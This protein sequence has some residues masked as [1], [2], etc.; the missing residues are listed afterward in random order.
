MMINSIKGKNI[1]SLYGDF[2]VDFRK[3]PLSDS[4]LFAIT[5]DT[6]SGKST[7]LDTLCLAL[8]GKTPRLGNDRK[9]DATNRYVYDPYTANITMRDPRR[10]MSNGESECYAEVNFTGNDGEEY[11]SSWSC[12]RAKTGTLQPA[13]IKLSLLKSNVPV[14]CERAIEEVLG[15]DFDQ[16]C[17]T[18][19]LSQGEFQKFLEASDNEK[20]DILEKITGTD[21][22]FQI[23]FEV[24]QKYLDARRNLENIQ[25]RTKGLVILSPEDR[26]NKEEDLKQAETEL[27]DKRVDSKSIDGQIKW[28]AERK[29]RF[30][31]LDAAQGESEAAKKADEGSAHIKKLVT[32]LESLRA[33]RPDFTL[34]KN[35]V[36][37]VETSQ[38][39]LKK[40]EESLSK[41]SE[42]QESAESALTNAQAEEASFKEG[43]YKIQQ[44]NILRA[45]DINSKMV[46]FDA[47]YQSR[48]TDVC[49]LSNAIDDLKRQITV[50]NTNIEQLKLSVSELEEWFKANDS[51]S[52]ICANFTEI[53]TMLSS[54]NTETA[55]SRNDEKKAQDEQKEL[56]RLKGILKEQTDRQVRIQ[57]LLPADIAL[58]RSHLVDGEVCPVCGSKVHPDAHKGL[59]DE[60][61]DEKK[62]NK[63]KAEAIEDLWEKIENTK[64]QISAA[65]I[66]KSTFDKTAKEH[67][68]EAMKTSN[69]LEPHF[70]NLTDWKTIPNLLPELTAIQK[71]WTEKN[72]DLQKAKSGKATD[73][74]NRDL[75]KKQAEDKRSE[76]TSKEGELTKVK[77]SLDSFSYELKCLIGEMTVDEAEKQNEAA[78]NARTNKVKE[79][80]KAKSDSDNN[81]SS[82]RGQN[83]KITETRDKS[84]SEKDEYEGKVNSWLDSANS[85]RTPEDLLDKDVLAKLFATYQESWIVSERAKLDKLKHNVETC[86]TIF[87]ERKAKLDEWEAT[88]G[89]PED[90]ISDETLKEQYDK[91]ENAVKEFED[92]KT[93]LIGALKADDQNLEAK[94]QYAGEEAKAQLTYDK[95]NVLDDVFG[96]Q[97]GKLFKRIAQSYALRTLVEH[98]NLQLD[99]FMSRYQLVKED[100]KSQ[101]DSLS[102]LVADSDQGGA[103]R[104]TSTLSG[105]EKFIVSL[106]LALGLSSLASNRMSVGSLFID[107]GFGSLDNSTLNTVMNSL[108]QM[109]I[110]G[111]KVGIISH[112]QEINDRVS[113]QIKVEKEG[114]GHSKITI[115]G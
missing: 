62:E 59:D 34:W 25:E 31:S 80:E 3:S 90:S 97:E 64:K 41:E 76:L 79:A 52:E 61:W 19:L 36:A 1:A 108:D 14:D 84:I 114:N 55:Y 20:S 30:S 26:K 56:D 54:Y 103:L 93:A 112:V 85:S 87:D 50:K 113:T 67:L 35:A 69:S 28:R 65:E 101:P 47:D 98:T 58:L 68:D 86:N 105:G 4:D 104:T 100:N 16:F 96:K 10:L 11:V 48:K 32:E 9:N 40:I 38:T 74:S 66:N 15:M 29:R 95:W 63:T 109:Q 5:G 94:K 13:L 106:S 39:Q 23:G 49:N 82:L 115:Q 42:S 57:G 17:K 7:I 111:R 51:F 2:E 78:L 18:V 37:N 88:P 110:Q 27:G 6:G 102:L 70:S 12:R 21:R 46:P 8:F 99:T 45:R 77:S 33:I 43:A 22:Y 44:D 71:Q 89:K 83:A 75:I 53:S 81:I 92:R 24:H 73:E 107:E 60:T 91:A 72:N